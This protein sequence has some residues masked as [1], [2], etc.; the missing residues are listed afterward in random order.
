MQLDMFPNEIAA[1][2]Q[3]RLVPKSSPLSVLNPYIDEDGLIRIR[4]KLR[5]TCLPEAS[6]N[7]IIL[8]AHPLL[9]L[10]IQHHHLRT[11]HIDSQLTVASLR[12][13]F[14]ILR[15][16]ATV[17]SVLYKCIPCTRERPD[18]PVEL[19]GDLPAASV[20]RTARA[21]VYTGVDYAGPI[22]VRTTPCRGHKS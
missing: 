16:R 1:L 3:K 6:K 14:W 15:A 12:Q 8:R 18:V 10:I 11:F 9:V 21:F 13:E 20:N 7:L 4:G 19:M 22:A 2:K 5:R 17:R